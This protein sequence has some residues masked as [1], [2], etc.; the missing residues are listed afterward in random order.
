[1][2]EETIQYGS[3]VTDKGAEKLALAAQAGEKIDIKYFVVGD[4]NG[5]STLPDPSQTSLKNECYRNEIKSYEVSPNDDKQL[6]VQC[7][8]PNDAGNFVMREWGLIDTDGDL[9]ALANVS[10]ISIVPYQ[11]GQI[12]N[13]NLRVYVQFDNAQI[14]AVNIVVKPT[15]EELFK[16]DLLNEVNSKLEHMKMWEADQADIERVFD[17]GWDPPEV[18]EYVEATEDDI[19]G[20]FN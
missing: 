20:L 16:Q 15:D 9:I 11:T 10:D 17:F 6:L 14:G 8:I 5:E 4:G 2:S 3:V 7:R 12:L 19:R 1:M 18:G 13:L